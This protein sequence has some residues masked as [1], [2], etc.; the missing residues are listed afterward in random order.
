VRDQ[1]PDLPV[2]LDPAKIARAVFLTEALRDDDLGKLNDAGL[3]SLVRD[4]VALREPQRRALLGKLKRPDLPGLVDVIV[5]DLKSK[6][7]RGFGEFAIHRAL[8]PEQLDAVVKAIPAL[9]ENEA[10]VL[11][12]LA[13]LAPSADAD[14]EF[15]A[16]ERDALLTRM[17]DYVKTL[18]PA[19]NTLKASVLRQRTGVRPAARHL[20]QGALH[21]IP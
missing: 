2:T 12:R 5:A 1:K 21:G 11:T 18:T 16:A 9:A 14:A 7:S 15:D 4:K 10:Y 19:F 8:L 20:R 17:W 6:E 3:E 13:K